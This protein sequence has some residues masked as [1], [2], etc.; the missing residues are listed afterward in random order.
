MPLCIILGPKCHHFVK[1]YK[2]VSCVRAEK[3]RQ[4]S[5]VTTAESKHEKFNLR[6]PIGMR[7]RLAE[8]GVKSGRS[9]NG[10]IVARLGES[11]DPSQSQVELIKTIQCLRSA[12]ESLTIE[13][14]AF[15]SR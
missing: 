1:A 13:L 14:S 11:L 10:E 6:M 2:L 15:R 8:A 3:R 9:M 4:I 5:E 7:A 12:V